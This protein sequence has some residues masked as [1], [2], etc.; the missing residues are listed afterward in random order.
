MGC[1]LSITVFPVLAGIVTDRKLTETR[2]G[3]RSL[4]SAGIGDAI[5]WCL[6]AR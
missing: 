5:T 4:L 2:M 3:V 6:V 1:A